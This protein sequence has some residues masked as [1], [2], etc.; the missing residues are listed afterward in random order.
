MP[1][2]HSPAS[3]MELAE[4]ITSNAP[5]AVCGTG[6]RSALGRPMSDLPVLSLARF[7]GVELYEPEELILEA[8]AATP[9]S[10]VQRRLA[11]RNQMLAF[12]PPDFSRLLGVRNAGTL[13][14]VLATGFAGPRRIKAGS[15]R[16][17]VLGVRGVTGRGEIF[18]AGARVMKNVTGYDVPKLLAGSWGTLAAITRVTFKVLPAPETEMTLLI[19]KNADPVALMSAALQSSCDVSAAAHVPGQGTCL[20]LEG[21]AVSV[22]A[23]RDALSRLLGAKCEVLEAAGS[24]KLWA[25][26]R[27]V[28]ALAADMQSIIWRVSVPPSD[29]TAYVRRVMEKAS[30]QSILDWGGGLV[31]LAL[32]PAPDGG[33][34]AVRGSLQEGHAMLFRAPQEL[35]RRIPVFQPQ[36]PALAALSARV[37]AAM[38][39]QGRLNPSRM[40]AGT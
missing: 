18:G 15:V 20:R 6:A 2:T 28:T 36:A 33:E 23:R 38:D 40:V 31:W 39:P 17:H 11:A 29:G 21:I 24:R 9:L 16:D 30:G 3:E 27:D 34:A 8:G 4:T 26:I 12:E 1:E 19:A 5:F 37:K 25:S 7:R 32:D 14:G 35:R 10:E 13:G 22:K